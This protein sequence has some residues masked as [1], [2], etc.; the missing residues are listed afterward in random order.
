MC[1]TDT[2]DFIY[3]AWCSIQVGN[4]DHFHIRIQLKCLFKCHRIHI[5]GIVF[6]IDEYRHT[7][8]IYNWI[9]CCIESHIRTEYPISRLYTG[10]LHSHMKPRRTCREGNTIFASYLLT[11]QTF[12][13]VDVLPDRG[14][15][16]R[17]IC[18]CYIFYLHFNSLPSLPQPPASASHTLLPYLRFL[19]FPPG[20]R[21][22]PSLAAALG[23]SFYSH[24]LRTSAGQA[25]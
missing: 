4:Y 6:C 2:S 13:F 21:S 1:F 20:G 17:L 14:H 5:P 9:H 12:H 8:L 22:A 3:L 25:D 15:P 7:A 24:T 10:K 23:Y 19:L 16:V 18:L 11:D